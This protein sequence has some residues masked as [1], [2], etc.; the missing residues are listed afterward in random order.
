MVVLPQDAIAVR[1]RLN[2]CLSFDHRVCDGLPVGR[3][4]AL[5]QRP[6]AMA[7][8]DLSTDLSPPARALLSSS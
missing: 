1:P 5:R 4:Q 8:G 7:P 2:L 3:L 6:E